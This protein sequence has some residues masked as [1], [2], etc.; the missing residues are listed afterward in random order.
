MTAK[1]KG[2]GWGG[3]HRVAHVHR[4]GTFSVARTFCK[5]CSLLSPVCHQCSLCNYV[6]TLEEIIK[7]NYT[8]EVL[9]KLF[10][11]FVPSLEERSGSSSEDR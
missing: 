4:E 5:I 7:Q 8:S 9:L 3:K 11:C 6:S 2:G 10:G 1:K